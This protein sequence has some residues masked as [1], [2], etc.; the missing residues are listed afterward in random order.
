MPE[1]W[2]SNPATL[3]QKDRDARWTVKFA[4]AKPKEDG[5]APPV[6]LAIPVFGYQNHISI[7]RGF[8]FI[9]KWEATDAAA[10]EGARRREG[11]LDKNNTAS[12]VSAD[13]AYR[14]AAN[15]A[16]MD[17]MSIARSPKAGPCLAR[18]GAPMPPN[19]KSARVSSMSSPSK[20]IA[21]SCS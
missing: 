5:L 9:R 11:L 12:G 14:S 15:E 8:G 7:D 13:P 10:Y 16:F 4:K 3:R 17:L 21:W 19:Q 6:D 1:H 18:S 2:K 20:R